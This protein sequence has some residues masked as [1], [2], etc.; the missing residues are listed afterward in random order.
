MRVGNG[1]KENDHTGGLASQAASVE[2]KGQGEMTRGQRGQVEG[3][4]RKVQGKGLATGSQ[5]RMG[6]LTRVGGGSRAL[7]TQGPSAT[8]S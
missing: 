2:S 7:E 5:E 6:K 4:R 8:S 3:R 1:R